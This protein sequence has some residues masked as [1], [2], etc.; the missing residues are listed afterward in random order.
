MNEKPNDKKDPLGG[1]PR[2]DVYDKPLDLFEYPFAAVEKKEKKVGGESNRFWDNPEVVRWKK[3]N[4][5]PSVFDPSV[6]RPTSEDS[7]R[8]K[9]HV[10]GGFLLGLYREH[11]LKFVIESSNLDWIKSVELIQQGSEIDKFD[12]V[13]LVVITQDGEKIRVQVKGNDYNR[14]RYEAI[15]EK[16]NRQ[17]VLNVLV[18]ELDDDYLALGSFLS[19]MQK[20]KTIENTHMKTRPIKSL[21]GSSEKEEN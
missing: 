10:K 8:M 19:E 15:R 9:K 7:E 4:P 17:G 5:L 2:G 3:G 12:G 13:D 6:F 18:D 16:Y 11:L 14:Q 1:D 21:F 20:Q